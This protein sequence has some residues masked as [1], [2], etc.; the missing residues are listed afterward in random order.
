MSSDDI[1]LLVSGQNEPTVLVIRSFSEPTCHHVCI[2]CVSMFR[3]YFLM[4]FINHCMSA[5]TFL[6]VKR[7][8]IE[9]CSGFAPSAWQKGLVLT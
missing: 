7:Q 6:W 5:E 1:W 3:H 2:Y 4:Q 9:I 8:L